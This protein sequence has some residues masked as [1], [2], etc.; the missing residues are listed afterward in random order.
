MWSHERQRASRERVGER[1]GR[2][3]G[4]PGVLALDLSG[5]GWP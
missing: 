1:E 5:G 2:R 3:E 4:A